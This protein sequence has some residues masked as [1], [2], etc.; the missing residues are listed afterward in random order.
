[1]SAGVVAV[2]VLS[3]LLVVRILRYRRVQ[4]I[5]DIY[6]SKPLT[7]WA[8]QQILH[9]SLF[10]EVPFTMHLGTVI[11]LFEVYGIVSTPPAR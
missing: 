4:S 3:Y 11:A 6:G 8:A 7:P 1:M 2:T 5:Q 9:I 10:Y